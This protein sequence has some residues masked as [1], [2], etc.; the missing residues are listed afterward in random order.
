VQ[1]VLDL[2]HL[3]DRQRLRLERLDLLG[4]LRLAAQPHDA[5]G[6]VH[7]DLALRDR[8]VAEQDGLDLVGDRGVVEMFR[9]RRLGLRLIGLTAAEQLLDVLDGPEGQLHP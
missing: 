3:G 4:R 6:R 7:I 5:V 1:E 8:L 2:L 9:L